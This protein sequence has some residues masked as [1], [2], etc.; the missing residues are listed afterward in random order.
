MRAL[1]GVL[2]GSVLS[3]PVVFWGL[4]KS[5]AG[6]TD[7]TE[8]KTAAVATVRPAARTSVVKRTA[9]VTRRAVP[10]DDYET[11][12]ASKMHIRVDDGSGGS[13]ARPEQEAL[14]QQ[15]NER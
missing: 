10:K 6:L 5:K 11:V 12:P 2:L 8:A 1:Q 4:S 13:G 9:P 3:I 14:P 7:G 15:P